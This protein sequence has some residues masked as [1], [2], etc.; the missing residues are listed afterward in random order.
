MR[1]LSCRMDS[2]AVAQMSRWAERE[3]ARESGRYWRGPYRITQ[4]GGEWEVRWY[5]SYIDRF[6]TL[7]AAKEW[8]ENDSRT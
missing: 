5:N 2:L 3:W 1:N 7:K 8:V 4:V 6:P